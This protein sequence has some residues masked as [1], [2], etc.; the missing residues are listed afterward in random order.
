[1]K[2]YLQGTL[3]HIQT[4]LYLKKC[5]WN[6]KDGQLFQSWIG[7]I[8]LSGKHTRSAKR[9]MTGG[10]RTQLDRSP[11][12]GDEHEGSDH[13]DGDHRFFNGGTLASSPKLDVEAED[14][15]EEP[16]T[17][18]DALDMDLVNGPNPWLPAYGFQLQH[19]SHFQPTHE[20]LRTN[21]SYST[22]DIRGRFGE[23]EERK[24]K[25]K[26][27]IIITIYPNTVLVQQVDFLE[28]I[29]EE[30]S[31]DLQSDSDR[32]GTTYW[33]GSDSET[34]SVIHIRANRLAGYLEN[35]SNNDIEEQVN[36]FAKNAERKI[37]YLGYKKDIR[38]HFI[39]I[40]ALTNLG[41]AGKWS[42]VVKFGRRSK[43]TDCDPQSDMK[44]ELHPRLFCFLWKDERLDGSGSE[45]NSGAARKK[46]RRGGK[47]NGGNEREHQ[48]VFDDYPASP[49][50]SRSS[51]SSRS[52]SL[53]QFE[54]LE[55]TCATLSPSSYSFDS[56]EY[57]NRSNASHPGNTSPDSLEQDYDKALPNGFGNVDHFSRIRPYRSFESL[58]TC[59]KEEEEFGHGC[60]TNGFTPL[61]LKRNAELSGTRSNGYHR[62]SRDFWH[63]DDEYEDNNDDDDDDDDDEDGVEED[64]EE[65]C[66]SRASKDNRSS[67]VELEDRLMVFG[68]C[69][70]ATSLDYRNTIDLREIGVESRRDALLDLKSGQ[71]GVSS[72]FRLLQTRLNIAGNMAHVR[73]NMVADHYHHHHH[74]HHHHHLPLHHHHYQTQHNQHEQQQLHG[75]EQHEQQHQRQ[76]WSNEDCFNF[77]F[78]DKS[79]SAPSLLTTVDESTRVPSSRSFFPTSNHFASISSN[80][81]ENYTRVASVPV[82]LNLCG[83]EATRDDDTPSPVSDPSS[84]PR[85]P[86]EMAEVSNSSDS[87]VQ[88]GEKRQSKKSLDEEEEEEAKRKKCSSSV[89]TQGS[90]YN[91]ILDGR[92]VD[93]ECAGGEH[94]S[95]KRVTSTVKTQD[96]AL[97]GMGAIEQLKRSQFEED[98]SNGNAASDG[99]DG[100]PTTVERTPSGKQQ[101]PW[102]VKN[103]ASYELAQQFEI[104]ER[105]FRSSKWRREIGNEGEKAGGRSVG[106]KRKVL[107]NASYELAQQ[108]D[109]IKALQSCRGAFQRM[110]ACDELEEPILARKS[111]LRLRVSDMVQQM[112]SS[113]TSNL[114]AAYRNDERSYMD[115]RPY[116]KSTEN[117]STQFSTAPFTR[118]PINELGQRLLGEKQKEKEVEG[119]EETLLSQIK[120]NSDP[121]SIYGDDPSARALVDDEVDLPCLET[122][123]IIGTS[124]V[125]GSASQGT[126]SNETIPHR[127]FSTL[128]RQRE[129][130]RENEK[131]E[132]EEEEAEE[133]DHRPIDDPSSEDKNESPST[134]PTTVLSSSACNGRNGSGE[135]LWRVIVEKQ[136]KE[137]TVEKVTKRE[138]ENEKRKKREK[139]REK[140]GAEEARG[141]E[142]QHGVHG[143][144]V[145]PP[146]GGS[147][148]S[149]GLEPDGERSG[150]PAV[151]VAVDTNHRGDR[152]KRH[153]ENAAATTAPVRVNDNDD[154]DDDNEEEGHAATVMSAT[155]TT[156]TTATTTNAKPRLF[157]TPASPVIVG[158]TIGNNDTSA[159][160]FQRNMV[161]DASSATTV[162]EERKKGGL[163]G[164]LQRFS[165]LR[166][167]GRSKVPRS[168]V[169][170]KSDTIGQVNRAKVTGEEKVKKEP[171]YIII[172]LHP[173]EEERQ[174]QDQQQQNVAENRGEDTGNGRT[175]ADVQRSTSNI[176]SLRDTDCRKVS[177]IYQHHIDKEASSARDRISR[178]EFV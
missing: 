124:S 164:F 12:V 7:I 32:S 115:T 175:V 20:D 159:A 140:E 111:S 163:G 42:R 1:M 172:P 48:A 23:N 11:P 49:R 162:K 44:K 9:L 61:Y 78:T 158:P 34:E 64:L 131:E 21:G 178:Q 74:H 68:D 15:E 176:R 143:V 19:R 14:D 39:A 110:D 84:V 120:K 85:E 4:D 38:R 79:Q 102:K 8:K 121:F 152:D 72:S 135:L 24:E 70:Y 37:M 161:V 41:N 166:F 119:E 117:I 130:Q 155:T 129:G 153:E 101:R 89:R 128:E 6:Y 99:I 63:E 71:A 73:N 94:C 46:R 58:D 109:Y 56:L 57:P 92:M 75:Y 54:S 10:H 55:R 148:N 116:S 100:G 103:N 88:S 112:S 82:D 29:L 157:V 156:T 167:S 151:A 108:C 69:T 146:P 170:K 22:V 171:D 86:D 118:I 147:S 142:Q 122:K 133:E 149:D 30:T 60:L 33:V 113:S 90:S 107:N 136:E 45:C 127:S 26:V 83:V 59:Q 80:L 138:E 144:G 87:G 125:E 134:I 96:R 160:R 53:L 150:N 141:H 17:T 50:S 16:S 126:S 27:A 28:T 47:Y 5:E 169:Q 104:D 35:G 123:P 168:E 13:H 173:P 93:E 91:A 43:L 76:G 62:P 40:L 174:K 31:D 95:R 177:R 66:A 106:R 98:S 18:F 2:K 3:F 97:D 137:A 132:E 25:A 36:V 65:Q 154:N 51:A 165:R 145:G 114:T 77:R 67:T 139:E 81:F 105:N 52:S